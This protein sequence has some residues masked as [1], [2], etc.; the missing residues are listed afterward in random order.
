M[1][2]GLT[3]DLRREWLDRGY[4]L[5]ETAEFDSE[6]TIAALENAL[7]DLGYET[8]RIGSAESLMRALTA[9]RSWDL[10]FNIAEGLYGFGR[11]AL[12]PCMLEA[13]GIPCTFA[14]PLGLTVTLHKAVTKRVVRDLGLPTPDFALVQS[15]QDVSCVALPFP[16][17]AKPVAEGTGK[18]VSPASM[19]RDKKQLTATCARLLHEFKQPVLVESYLPGREFTVGVAGTGA[20]ARALAVMEVVLNDRA[21]PGA[22][23]Y[24]NKAEYE[25]RVKYHLARDKAAHQAAALAV[26]AHQGLGL[27]DVSRV[28]IRLDAAENPAFMEVNPLPGL[29]PGHSDL[30]IMCALAGISYQELI[31]VIMTSARERVPSAVRPEERGR[32]CA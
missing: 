25:D 24:E 9:G 29:H 20:D 19:I 13:R 28:D 4:T 23:T 17:F 3:F 5:E 16:V 14:D 27:R 7:Q 1:L 15:L 30:P 10:V 12:V 22:Y 32:L 11:E 26:A 8:E 31:A 21:Q 6:E 2:V 18:G